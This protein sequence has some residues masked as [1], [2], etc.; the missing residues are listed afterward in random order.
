MSKKSKIQKA[1]EKQANKQTAM[2]ILDWS[3]FMFKIKLFLWWS[4]LGRAVARFFHCNRR[5]HK[6]TTAMVGWE[7]PQKKIKEEVNYIKCI[8][9]NYLF[10]TSKK[11]K[12]TYQRIK[13]REMGSM[14]RAFDSILKKPEKAEVKR[15]AEQLKDKKKVKK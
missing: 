7:D 4:E 14:K 13:E 3:F 9:C 8:N 10:F 12:E 11:D 5:C 15:I 6:I 1:I 2:R